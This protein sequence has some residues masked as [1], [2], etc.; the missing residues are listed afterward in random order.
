MQ[1]YLDIPVNKLEHK[2]IQ[3]YVSHLPVIFLYNKLLPSLFHTV[4]SVILGYTLYR[5]PFFPF[6]NLLFTVSHF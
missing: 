1:Q 6:Q 2:K 5:D 4:Q 3:P